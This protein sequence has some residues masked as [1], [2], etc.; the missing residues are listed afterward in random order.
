MPTKLNAAAVV[1]AAATLCALSG[2]NALAAAAVPSP[3]PSASPKTLDAIVVTAQRHAERIRN[4]PRQTFVVTS[5]ELE[6]LGARTVADAL[7]YAAGT[8]V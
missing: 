8:V 2:G 4:T 1:L 5:G 6:R 3:S 7:R